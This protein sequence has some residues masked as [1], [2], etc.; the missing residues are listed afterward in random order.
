ME[1]G[2]YAQIQLIIFLTFAIFILLMADIAY[3]IMTNGDIRWHNALIY[4]SFALSIPILFVVSVIMKLIRPQLGF[5]D[6]LITAYAPVLF[7]GFILLSQLLP[8]S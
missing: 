4:Q 7:W 6:I 1:N 2:E 5:E 8:G 3:C